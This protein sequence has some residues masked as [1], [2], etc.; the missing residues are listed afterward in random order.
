M[1]KEAIKTEPS[2]ITIHIYNILQIY[3]DFKSDFHEN[4]F[5]ECLHSF[6]I[7]AINSAT[8]F[9]FRWIVENSW[10][11]LNTTNEPEAWKRNV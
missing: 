5:F 1:E 8:H 9:G 10:N 11:V 3:I 6:V 7:Q 2:D 4:Y